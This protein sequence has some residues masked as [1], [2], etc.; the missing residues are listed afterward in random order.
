[1]IQEEAA[2]NSSS[3]HHKR[4]VLIG[5]FPP[6]LHGASTI[7]SQLSQYIRNCGVEVREINIAPSTYAKGTR[8]HLSRLI[9]LTKAALT[10]L[11]IPR[12]VP[13]LINV[14]G[15]Y[16]IFYNIFLAAIIKIKNAP[17]ALYHHSS[18]YVYKRSVLMACLIAICGRNTLHIACSTAMLRELQKRYRDLVKTIVISNAAWVNSGHHAVGDVENDAIRL[19]FLSNLNPEKGLFRAIDTL[20]KLRN[21]GLK[22]RLIIAGSMPSTGDGPDFDLLKHEFGKN[23]SYLGKVTGETKSN[24]FKGIDYFLFPSLYQ[25]ETQSLVVSE[26]LSYGVP[27]IAFNHRFVKELLGAGSLAIETEASYPDEAAAWVAEGAA[28]TAI[29]AQRRK[30]AHESFDIHSVAALGQKTKLLDWF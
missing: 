22:A 10:I 11:F 16:G 12:G 2:M 5:P 3:R 9:R 8:Y 30:D 28:N 13:C 1:M 24:F 26:A 15:G 7:N 14:D 19:G 27:V 20:R 4:A 29:Y 18:R 25:H 6:P 17:L 23:L 21:S